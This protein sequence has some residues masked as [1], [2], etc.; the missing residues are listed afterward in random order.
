MHTYT[1]KGRYD[2]IYL[3]FLKL[4]NLDMENRLVVARGQEWV[5]EYEGKGVRLL[6]G[7]MRAS[8]G[9]GTIL[10]LRVG[11]GYMDLHTW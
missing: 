10:G 7:Q 11:C 6:K 9:N 2:S 3:I 8:C 5:K 4:Q 1:P